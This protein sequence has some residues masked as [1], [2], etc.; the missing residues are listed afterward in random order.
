MTDT[1]AV[2][3]LCQVVV[4]GPSQVTIDELYELVNRGW[5]EL[6]KGA[7]DDGVRAL[8]IFILEPIT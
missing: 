4:D 7:T 2:M 6:L 3:A 5:Y 1:E 8:G